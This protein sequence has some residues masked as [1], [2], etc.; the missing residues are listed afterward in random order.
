MAG[1]AR[2]YVC[3]RRAAHVDPVRLVVRDGLVRWVVNHLAV[4]GPRD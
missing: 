4:G 1:Y 3:G 2:G